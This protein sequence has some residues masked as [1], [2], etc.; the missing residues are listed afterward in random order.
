MRLQGKRV[1]VTGGAVRIGRAISKAF[2]SAGFKVAIHCNRSKVDAFKLLEELGG[3]RAGHSVVCEDLA[4]PEAA[5][6]IFKACGR[7]DI[8]VCNASVYRPMPLAMEGAADIASHFTVN[9]AAPLSL[10]QEF[11]AQKISGGAIINILDE[12][13][14]R[15]TA[16]DGS[17]ELSKKMLAEATIALAKS[18]APG[19]RVS[20]VAPG[21]VMPPAGSHLTMRKHLSRMPLRKAPSPE[22]VAAACIFLASQDSITGQ[23]LFVDGGEHLNG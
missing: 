22:D 14:C 16:R 6:R 23:I 4:E 9:L 1:L 20:A 15:S 5:G 2:A 10:A 13:I 7:I 8:L 3:S 12:R 21:A 17:Y 18:L 11:A 19:I